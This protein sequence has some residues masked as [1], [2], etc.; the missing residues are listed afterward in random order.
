LNIYEGTFSGEGDCVPATFELSFALKDAEAANNACENI[1]N[2]LK[3]FFEL[4]DVKEHDF[5]KTF[6]GVKVRV[7]G[8]KFFIGS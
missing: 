8:N 3:K 7:D 1:G 5:A 2:H 4:D 6:A